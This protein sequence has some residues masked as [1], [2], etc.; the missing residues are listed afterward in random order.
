M[1]RVLCPFSNEEAEATRPWAVNAGSRPP[2]FG[3]GTQEE[4]AF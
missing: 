3:G 4:S 2:V 1:W